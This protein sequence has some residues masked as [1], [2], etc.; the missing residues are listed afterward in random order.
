MAG[1][2][3]GDARVRFRVGA[4]S[5]PGLVARRM[6][7][8][9]PRPLSQHRVCSAVWRPSFLFTAALKLK[10]WEVSSGQFP[11]ACSALGGPVPVAT[12][13]RHTGHG[14]QERA[15]DFTFSSVT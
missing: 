6:A 11:S 2:Q 14:L 4:G 9:R 5:Q 1:P 12:T 15:K 10:A 3:C 8:C 7:F 13:A